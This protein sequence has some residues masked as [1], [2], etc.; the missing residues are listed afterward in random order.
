MHDVSTTGDAVPPYVWRRR[1]DERLVALLAP[2][3]AFSPLTGRVAGSPHP[4]AL[5]LWADHPA[6][7]HRVVLFVGLVRAFEIIWQPH[8]FRVDAA[9]TFPPA[10]RGVVPWSTWMTPADAPRMASLL[11]GVL[12]EAAPSLST[13]RNIAYA[14]LIRSRDRALIAQGFVGTFRDKTSRRALMAETADDVV[15]AV[16]R[17]GLPGFVP[18]MKPSTDALFAQ[19]GGGLIVTEIE[20][21]RAAE[22]A[23]APAQAIVCLRLLRTWIDRDPGAPSELARV[24]AD[25]RSLGLVP[26]GPAVNARP[27]VSS[28]LVALETGISDRLRGRLVAVW[29]A[30]GDAGIPEAAE[31][32]VEEVSADGVRVP[33]R[34]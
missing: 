26:A 29:R 33:V 28:A 13:G 21:S 1:P 27:S 23:Y 31:L 4:L 11:A 22:V 2:G 15:A 20:S 10:A 7:P 8:R 18:A 12:E 6:Q 3:G 19:A 5:H 25:R 32:T 24:L 16:R 9:R 34:A 17:A 30:L 14:G